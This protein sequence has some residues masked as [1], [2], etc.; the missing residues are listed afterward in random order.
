MTPTTTAAASAGGTRRWRCRPCSRRSRAPGSERPRSEPV[1][2][3]PGIGYIRRREPPTP[4][5]EQVM[6]PRV[7]PRVAIAS[8]AACLLVVA[9]ANAAMTIGQTPTVTPPTTCLG[10]VD[11]IQAIVTAGSTY[12]VPATVPQWTLT[13]WSTF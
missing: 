3:G 11:D 5:K 2:T 8:I 9:P 10:P 4:G 13:S 6:G 7:A 1:A 12:Q